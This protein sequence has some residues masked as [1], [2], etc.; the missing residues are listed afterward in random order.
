MAGFAPGRR[1]VICPSGS[2][3]GTRSTRTSTAGSRRSTPRCSGGSEVRLLSRLGPVAAV[4][5]LSTPHPEVSLPFCDFAHA[6]TDSRS[7]SHMDEAAVWDDLAQ[8]GFRGAGT[9]SSV[10]V[11]RDP[12]CSRRTPGA[13]A[14]WGRVPGAAQRQARPLPEMPVESAGGAPS[15]CVVLTARPARELMKVRTRD[16]TG[17]QRKSRAGWVDRPLLLARTGAYGAVETT[18]QS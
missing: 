8:A 4:R 2:G 17:L 12:T 10:K 3:T 14:S 18:G 9:V 6:F 11:C 13:H 16:R 5:S 15:P 1:G 7:A